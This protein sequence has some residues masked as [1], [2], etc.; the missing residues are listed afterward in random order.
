MRKNIKNTKVAVRIRKSEYHNEWYLY[1][2]SYPVVLPN[3]EKPQRIR[4]YL[5]RTI[6]TPIWDKKRTARTKPDGS[7]SFKVKRDINGIIQCKSDF[8]NE[9]CLYADGVRK[10]RQR[11]YDNANL[12]NDNEKGA[13]ERKEKLKENFIKYFKAT[14]RKRH[15]NSSNS[16]QVNWNRTIELIELFYGEYLPFSKIDLSFAED[17]KNK[18]KDAPCSGGKKGRISNST[19]STYYSIFKACLKQAFIDDYLPI[20]LSAKIKGIRVIQ[21]KREYL[22]IEEINRLA[23]TS[24]ELPVLKRASLF[25]ILTGLRLSDIQKLSWKEIVVENGQGK[26]LF[27]QQKTKGVEYTPISNQAL[28]LCGTPDL[29][30][31]VVFE[32]LPDSSWI[33][34]PLK[35]WIT[36]S[37]IQKHITFHCFRHTYATLQLANGT[38]IY[39]VSKMLGHTNVATTQIYSK[40]VDGKK[41]MASQVIQIEINN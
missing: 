12:Y 8:D 27:T 3:K 19:S 26:L 37:G 24:C 33:S 13:L 41:D 6:T 22:T 4:E 16:I 39:T 1:V 18:I 21:S 32:D 23:S 7:K 28:E 5:N 29:P 25:S 17:F 10:L 2:E 34:R 30:E 36:E 40:V 11:E 31:K 9:S 35:K 14:L 38:D 15:K 20:D